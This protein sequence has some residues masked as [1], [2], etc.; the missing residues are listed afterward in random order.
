MS[1][2]IETPIIAYFK[3]YK[4]SYFN[5]FK[6]TH[7]QPSSLLLAKSLMAVFH[8]IQTCDCKL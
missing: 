3:M 7:L 2:N 8:L 1:R 5:N 6:F 4:Y